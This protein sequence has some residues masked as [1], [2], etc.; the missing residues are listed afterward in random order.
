MLGLADERGDL[1]L[2]EWKGH[3]SILT[4]PDSL[5]PREPRQILSQLDTPCSPQT[6]ARPHTPLVGVRDAM[7]PISQGMYPRGWR[8]AA[9][10]IHS[11]VHWL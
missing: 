11:P 6:L 2:T 7:N 9:P 4:A 5:F 1:N 3:V 8:S 10:E